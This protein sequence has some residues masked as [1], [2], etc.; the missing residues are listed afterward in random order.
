MNNFIH[1]LAFDYNKHYGSYSRWNYFKCSRRDISC[2]FEANYK[3]YAFKENR[4]TSITFREEHFLTEL[5]NKIS[6]Y[7]SSRVFKELQK[8]PKE[9]P[10]KIK[11]SLTSILISTFKLIVR[12]FK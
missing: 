4:Q 12:L 7:N 3:N 11:K 9:E 2:I 8:L 10:F 1:H 5:L 6:P